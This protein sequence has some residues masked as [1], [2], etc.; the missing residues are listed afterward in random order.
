M[1]RCER[2]Q[3][4]DKRFRT[5]ISLIKTE[6]DGKGCAELFEF[7]IFDNIRSARFS[8][9]K[10]LNE[11]AQKKKHTQKMKRKQNQEKRG[12][13]HPFGVLVITKTAGQTNQHNDH[14]AE[15]LAQV[16]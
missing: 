11:E 6:R 10:A 13:A 16:S 7:V 1:A 3:T 9:P 14:E 15:I 5:A 2:E 8:I 12:E 4:D